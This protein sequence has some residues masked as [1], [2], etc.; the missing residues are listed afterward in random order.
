MVTW[1]PDAE[2]DGGETEALAGPFGFT[3]AAAGGAAS[4]CAT[5]AAE[6][7]FSES[8]A[9]SEGEAAAP[10]FAERCAEDPRCAGWLRDVRCS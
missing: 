3:L 1:A 10:S 4:S 6:R 7:S 8:S 9:A 5:D 2:L